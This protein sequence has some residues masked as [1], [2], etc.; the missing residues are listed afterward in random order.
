MTLIIINL[1]YLLTISS[2]ATWMNTTLLPPKRPFYLIGHMANSIGEIDDYLNRGANAIEADVQFDSNGSMIKTYHGPPCDDCSKHCDNQQNIIPYLIHL[3]KLS[4]PD[5]PFYN[6]KLVLFFM[7]IKITNLTNSRKA[8]AGV[9]LASKL[10]TY[11][12]NSD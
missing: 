10:V 8:N 9:D 11:L 12:L 5:S 3:N 1:L 4:K 2:G 7:D 6:S